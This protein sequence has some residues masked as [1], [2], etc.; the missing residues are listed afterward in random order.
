MFPAPKNSKEWVP[1]PYPVFTKLIARI[2]A[3]LINFALGIPLL[4]NWVNQFLQNRAST[5]GK[6]RPYRLSCKADYTSFDSLTDKTYFGR[7]LPPVPKPS[8]SLPSTGDLLKIL[9]KREDEVETLCPR[10]TLLFPTFAQHL[11]DSFIN[12]KVDREK[13][14]EEGR[15]VFEL[16]RTDS[17]NEIGLSPLYGENN[18]QTTQLRELSEKTGRKGRLKTQI[19]EGQEEWAPFLYD[20]KGRKKSEF[21][22]L[23]DPQGID[24]VLG[25][26]PNGESS[27]ANKKAAIFAFGGPRANLN[28]NIVAWNI[29]LLREHNR[30]ALEVEKSEPTWNDERVFQT[31]RN[32]TLVI[33]LKLVIEEY[34]K[35]ISGVNFRVQPGKWMWNAAWNKTN[36]MSVEF[37]ILYRWHSLIPNTTNW[38]SSKDVTVIDSL[39]NNLLLLDKSK[40]CGANLRDI[41]VDICQTRITSFQINNTEDWM[42]FRESYAI[43]QGRENNVASYADYCEYLGMKRPSTFKDIS[44]WPEVQKKLEQLYKTPDRVEFYVGLIAADHSPGGKIFGEVSQLF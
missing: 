13:S 26:V 25:M 9:F 34:I 36:W 2:K 18:E 3:L 38:G 33:Y 31:A 35:H 12:T 10:S 5:S 37:A 44:L 14:R 1:P 27:K 39:F 17:K 19:L 42:V 7:H 8:P 11:I 32:I 23:A 29:L 30:I 41:F 15:T 28:P 43:N 21:N 40:G 20:K 4:G 16:G 6:N 22:K 24:H